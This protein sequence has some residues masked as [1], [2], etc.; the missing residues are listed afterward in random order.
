MQLRPPSPP[1]GFMFVENPDEATHVWDHD[2]SINEL[3]CAYSRSLLAW[4]KK[5]PT[6]VV[7]TVE[8][9]V[10]QRTIVE[11]EVTYSAQ[12]IFGVIVADAIR[13]LGN[14]AFGNTNYKI[15]FKDI[16]GQEREFN[17]TDWPDFPF[18]VCMVRS[19]VVK[20]D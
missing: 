3:P 7:E 1:E 18:H 19:N 9:K 10:K 4:L 17:P 11:Q 15:Y 6:E 8:L 2:R 13:L 20:A 14:Q 5:L 16:A 12:E